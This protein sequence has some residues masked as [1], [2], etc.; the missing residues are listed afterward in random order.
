MLPNKTEKQILN[1]AHQLEL[2]KESELL[3]HYCRCEDGIEVQTN[4]SFHWGMG[5]MKTT[6]K[7]PTEKSVELSDKYTK[8]KIGN[9]III[10]KS[11]DHIQSLLTTMQS[12]ALDYVN[13]K[14]KEERERKINGEEKRI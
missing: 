5:V 10:G 2:N 9:N 11:E 7:N 14:L 1:K 4:R 6:I 8:K 12:M 3:A 13:Y